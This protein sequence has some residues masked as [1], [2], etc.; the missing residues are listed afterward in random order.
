MLD[1]EWRDEHM[2][3]ANGHFMHSR[4]KWVRIA[5]VAA[6]IVYV[7]LTGEVDGV[8]FIYFQF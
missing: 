8:S 2:A 6:L 3:A 5:S 7:V 1:K 4:H